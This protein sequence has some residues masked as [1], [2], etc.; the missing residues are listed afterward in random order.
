MKLWSVL[1]YKWLRVVKA[2]GEGAGGGVRRVQLSVA[3]EAS[4]KYY[5]LVCSAGRIKPWSLFPNYTEFWLVV[6]GN[7]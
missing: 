1:G 4:I 2:G 5:L 6:R 3:S 7:L